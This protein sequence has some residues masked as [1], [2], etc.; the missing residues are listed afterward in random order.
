MLSKKL[1]QSDSSLSYP[2]GKMRCSLAA[3]GSLTMNRTLSLSGI[4]IAL[5]LAL[6]ACA[7]EPAPAPAPAPTRTPTPSLSSVSFEDGA[8]LPPN[9]DISLGD[10]FAYDDGWEEIAEAASP[11]R[12]GYVN[13]DRTCVAS[14]RMGALGAE[15]DMTDQDAT[16]A[17]IAAKLG[18]NLAELD[19]LIDD[20]YFLRYGPGNARVANRQYSVTINGSGRFVAVRAFVAVDY[21][22][23]VNIHCEGVDV[24]AAAMEA[25]SKNLLAIDPDARS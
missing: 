5:V 4:A 8:S 21:S 13:A 3:I 22:V 2:Q 23:S 24:N 15:S 1:I 18:T 17:V 16:D 10:G 12:W 9:T 19:G 6:S 7:A 20:G 25:L 11:G 14:F